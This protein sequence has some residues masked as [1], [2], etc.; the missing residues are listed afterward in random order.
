MKRCDG[1]HASLAKMVEYY[2]AASRL[3]GEFGRKLAA[4][5]HLRDGGSVYDDRTA[6][7]QHD[8]PAVAGGW[9]A[10]HRAAHERASNALRVG[11]ELDAAADAIEAWIKEQ[12]ALKKRLM[13]ELYKFKAGMS[14]S[15][16]LISK[17]SLVLVC[18]FWWH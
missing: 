17:V 2:R 15:G 12:T 3:E 5:T 16:A 13:D 11:H 4:L 7:A 8:V 1:G 10:V 14:E 6:V 18:A 9:E